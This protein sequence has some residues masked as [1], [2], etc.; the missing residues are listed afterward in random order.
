M[1]SRCPDRRVREPA[2]RDYEL[3]S[4]VIVQQETNKTDCHR[5]YWQGDEDH[6]APGRCGLYDEEFVGFLDGPR[7]GKSEKPP[8]N[9][10]LIRASLKLVSRDDDDHKRPRLG[11]RTSGRSRFRL[12]KFGSG[13]IH[14]MCRWVN[15]HCPGS[16]WSS[17]CLHDLEPAWRALARNFK[18]AVSAARERLPTVEPRSIHAGSDRQVR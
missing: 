3:L 11:H 2:T 16:D 17:H 18:L 4:F 1:S 7:I 10:N 14:F 9:Q 15:V 8:E 5:W 12:L 13:Q 6:R